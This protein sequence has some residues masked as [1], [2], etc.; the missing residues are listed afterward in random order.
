MYW[1]IFL[2]EMIKNLILTSNEFGGLGSEKNSA[3]N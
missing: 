1:K 2:D 3:M